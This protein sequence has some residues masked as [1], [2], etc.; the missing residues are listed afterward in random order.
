MITRLSAFVFG[1]NPNDEGAQTQQ[2]PPQKTEI[3]TV[4]TESEPSTSQ[5]TNAQGPMVSSNLVTSFSFDDE[6]RGKQEDWVFIDVLNK[7]LEA[8]SKMECQK[9]LK[10]EEAPSGI[11]A[12]SAG[13]SPPATP[14][15]ADSEAGW[16]VTPPACFVTRRP[17]PPIAASP[18]DNLLIEHPSMSV[19]VSSEGVST[20]RNAIIDAISAPSSAIAEEDVTSKFIYLFHYI[21]L[22]ALF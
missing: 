19:Y 8:Q 22:N 3:E 16:L 13:Q 5:V 15:S 11:F 6:S 9:P 12:R 18:M 10:S 17:L 14:N 2:N 20:C 21:V 7:H 1:T 4:N